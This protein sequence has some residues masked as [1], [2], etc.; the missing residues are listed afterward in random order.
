MLQKAAQPVAV[1]QQ[2]IEHALVTVFG[3]GLDQRR[4]QLFDLDRLR[5]GFADTIEQITEGRLAVSIAHRTVERDT[6][7]EVSQLAVVRKA[8]VTA[9]E[10]T[11]ERMGVGQADLAHIGLT[12]MANHHFTFDGITLHQLRDFRLAA[13]SRS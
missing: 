10:F 3:T 9:P 6:R 4:Q 8:P 13:G 12:N 5:E 1:T 2:A 11:H 7:A